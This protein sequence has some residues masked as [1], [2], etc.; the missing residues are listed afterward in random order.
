VSEF[1]KSNSR[2]DEA[3]LKAKDAS[4]L[5][6]ILDHVLGQQ[7]VSTRGQSGVFDRT[8]DAE[9]PSASETSPSPS[10]VAGGQGRLVRMFYPY[11]NA[12]FEIYGATEGELDSQESAIRAMY[13][14]QG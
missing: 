11:G 12:R 6:E 2:I 4:E 9:V 7:G 10:F 3:I 14:T 13:P 8:A 1:M 5:R